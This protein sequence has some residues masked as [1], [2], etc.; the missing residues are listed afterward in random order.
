LTRLAAMMKLFVDTDSTES[1]FSRVTCLT[2][3]RTSRRVGNYI[4]NVE[5]IFTARVFL[6]YPTYAGLSFPHRTAQRRLFF[7]YTASLCFDS[8]PSFLFEFHCLPPLGIST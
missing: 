4:Q 6:F 5:R 1:Q 3:A 8:H 7:F 2:W